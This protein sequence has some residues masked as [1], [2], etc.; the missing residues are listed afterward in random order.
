MRRATSTAQGQTCHPGLN[1]LRVGLRRCRLD[2][3][4][5]TLGE[6]EDHLAGEISRCPLTAA[7]PECLADNTTARA[8]LS[9]ISFTGTAQKGFRF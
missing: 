9:S 2:S 4:P 7:I 6:R 5:R 3:V 8:C 1:P